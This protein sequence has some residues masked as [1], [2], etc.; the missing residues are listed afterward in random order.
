MTSL[1]RKL[2][3]GI[4][5]ALTL[6]TAT[7]AA[8]SS[9]VVT[10]Y[11]SPVTVMNA[12]S[13]QQFIVTS[14]GGVS[15]RV[16]WNVY[17]TGCSGSGCGN[18]SLLGGLYTAP[19]TVS[20]SISVLITATSLVDS[21]TSSITI[22]VNGLSQGAGGTSVS[23]TPPGP[24][25]LAA[26]ASQPFSATVVGPA[27]TAVNW[28][29]GGGTCGGNC[30]TIT[31]A[32]VYTAPVGLVQTLSAIITAT[33]QAT[34]TA[35]ASV[36]VTLVPVVAVAIGQFNSQMVPGA[37]QLFVAT[38]SGSLFQ[39]VQWSVSGAGCAGSSCGT[40]ST[41][42]LYIAPSSVASTLN[43]TVKATA[44]ADPTKFATAA[45]AV[46]PIVVVSVSP[47][48]LS[49][50]I[51]AM[52]QFSVSITGAANTAVMWSIA[53]C[54]NPYPA[55]G[56]ISPITAS[57]ALYQAPAAIPSPASVNVTATLT[58]DPSHKSGSAP[59]TIVPYSN[60]RLNGQYA[61]LFRGYDSSGSYQAAG[62]FTADGNGNLTNGV[63][64]INCGAGPADPI[65]NPIPVSAQ[66]F[67]GTY[68]VNADGRGTFTINPTSGPSQTF[69]LAVLTSNAKA[70]FIESDSTSGIRG[71]GVLE[72]QDPSA[73]SAFTAPNFGAGF[74]F[75]LSGVDSSG[76][77]LAAIGA[78]GLSIDFFTNLPKITTGKLDVNDNG[79]LSCYPSEGSCT[80]W[81]PPFQTFSGAYSV[82]SPN[83]R[84]TASF[85][86]LGFDGANAGGVAT[87]TTTFNFSMYVISSGEF[88]LLS[89]DPGGTGT[90]PGSVQ[91]PVFSG[92]ALEQLTQS[93]SAFQQGTTLV[94]WSGWSKVSAPGTPGVPQA[95]IGQLSLDNLGNIT[96]LFYDVNSGGVTT[97]GNDQTLCYTTNK[98][99]K[100]VPNGNCTYAAQ[101]NSDTV[102]SAGPPIG[103]L[104][105]PI[106]LFRA[107]PIST[108]TAFLLGAGSSVTV[109][110]MEVQ[111]PFSFPAPFMFGSDLMVAPNA[112]LISGSGS[113]VPSGQTTGPVTGDQDESSSTGFVA[114]VPFVGKYGPTTLPSNGRGFM[115]LDS[116]IVFW[117]I[118]PY[119]TIAFDVDPGAVPNLIVFEY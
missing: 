68:S 90:L 32:G 101:L 35:S 69:T 44:K 108:N 9:F 11:P 98:K 71:S 73:F 86:V 117:V 29:V 24:L 119:K 94:S 5:I 56:M 17:G 66:A 23:I 114:N 87:D 78:V 105:N 51:N 57:T 3:P 47:A 52:Q 37:S 43:V 27:N 96:N 2:L 100:N 103:T 38:V 107:F 89:M 113:L 74:A 115:Y 13:Q 8:G 30:G 83:G 7:L 19:A 110:K 111:D 4:V 112:S 15:P 80:S 28:T 85:S 40:I 18:I 118:S 49:L 77:P 12:G 25:Q 10:G 60:S 82:I 88:F 46:G 65:C 16:F 102:L 81:L 109:G 116:T 34:P 1:V 93:A 106:P 97:F 75:S 64:D 39:G 6:V 54:S 20:G 70:R 22:T 59:V 50:S 84:G 91:N 45:I 48:P 21:T 63:E 104:P 36:T 41:S 58:L 76:Q 67:T 61:F 55:C 26:G 99:G 31:P 79:T 33:S 14:A 72:K 92:E 62:S 53:G 42:G 95:G